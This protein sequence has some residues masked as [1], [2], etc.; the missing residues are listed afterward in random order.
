MNTKVTISMLASWKLK[1]RHLQQW[2]IGMLSLICLALSGQFLSGAN[3]AGQGAG[4]GAGMLPNVEPGT[5]FSTIAAGGDQSLAV[6]S[7]RTV[8]GWGANFLG[9]SI[10]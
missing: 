5:T 4:W 10:V 2:Q 7:D 6:K 1:G 8:L 9:E 3:L